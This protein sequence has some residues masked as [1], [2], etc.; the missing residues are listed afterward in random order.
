MQRRFRAVFSRTRSPPQFGI[1]FR[2]AGSPLDYGDGAPVTIPSS[3]NP[4]HSTARLVSRFR[5]ALPPW[6]IALAG[7]AL[8]G[9]AMGASALAALLVDRWE[10]PALIRTVVLLFTCGGAIAFPIA[11]ALARLLA[12]GA[13]PEPAFAAIFVSLATATIGFTALF[14]ALCYRSYYAQWHAEPLTHLWAIQF[15]HTAAGAVYQFAVLGLRLYFPVG[16]VAL[17]GGALMSLRFVRHAR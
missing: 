14:F 2:E 6:R 9:P 10:T 4:P 13:R 16:F 3:R 11:L 7:A 1:R 15:I 12:S 17:F 8:W 5:T